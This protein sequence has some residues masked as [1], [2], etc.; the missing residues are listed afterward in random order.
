MPLFSNSA[1]EKDI[2]I[3][4]QYGDNL[5]RIIYLPAARQSGWEPLGDKKSKKDVVNDDKLSNNISRAKSKVR[6]YALCNDWDY[7]CTFTL[8]KEKYDRYNLPLFE[9]DF[10]EFLHNYNR[11]CSD[12]EKVRYL[13]VPEKHKDGAWHMH[14]FIRGIRSCDLHKNEHNRLTWS[15]YNDKFGFISMERIRSIEKA[16]SYCMKYLVKDLDKSVTERN[17]RLFLSSKGL[18]TAVKIF[19]GYADFQGAWDWEHPDGYCKIKNVDLR[20]NDI[21]EYIGGI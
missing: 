1:Y 15:Q 19:Q 3:V 20:I 14:G 8:D 17:K 12:V 18:N 10:S 6:E 4:K 11:R 13:L 16:S 2:F 21:S 9:K 7:W 5:A